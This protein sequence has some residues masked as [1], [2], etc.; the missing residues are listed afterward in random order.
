[1]LW[2]YCKGRKKWQVEAFCFSVPELH[3]NEQN[4]YTILQVLDLRCQGEERQ[5]CAS[6]A[7]YASYETPSCTFLMKANQI[8]GCIKR[9]AGSTLREWILPLHSALV[10]PHLECCVVFWCPQ[11]KKGMESVGASPEEN[12]EVDIDKRTGATPL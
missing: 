8:L 2:L 5:P 9:S 1:M 3:I 4:K 7:S 12:H 10:R 11:H 6:C